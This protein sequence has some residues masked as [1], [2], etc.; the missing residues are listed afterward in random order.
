M[1][2][3]DSKDQMQLSANE[4]MLS[5]ESFILITVGKKGKATSY[6]AVASNAHAA[7]LALECKEM[8]KLTEDQ[9]MCRFDDDEEE[10]D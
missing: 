6:R 8:A 9:A 5:C 3:Y 1:N 7:L 10:D 4:S 2:Y